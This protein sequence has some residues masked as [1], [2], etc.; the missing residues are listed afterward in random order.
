MLFLIKLLPNFLLFSKN[1]F[2]QIYTLQAT[3]RCLLSD[4]TDAFSVQNK[5]TDIYDLSWR[6]AYGRRIHVYSSEC[7]SNDLI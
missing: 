2:C 4:F 3:L 1:V 5:L 7:C 6:K